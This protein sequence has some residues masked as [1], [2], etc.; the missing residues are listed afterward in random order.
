M[1]NIGCYSM[2]IKALQGRK[3]ASLISIPQLKK[4]AGD[5]MSSPVY[6]KTVAS[7]CCA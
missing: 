3:S 1:V 5:K 6:Y 4:T 7:G 2:Q